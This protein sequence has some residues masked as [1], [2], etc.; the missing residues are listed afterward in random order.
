MAASAF[1]G[2]QITA[3][4]TE[5]AVRTAY[6]AQIARMPRVEKTRIRYILLPRR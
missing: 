2:E 5:V 3:S 1:I 6:E 4:V